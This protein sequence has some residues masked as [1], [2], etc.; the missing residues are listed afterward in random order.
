MREMTAG[1]RA[2]LAVTDV[3]GSPVFLPV[4]TGTFDATGTWQVS[5][6]VPPGFSGLTVLLRA[7]AMDA[8]G[9]LRDSLDEIV[10]VQ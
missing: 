4:A 9:K 2:L 3:D 7:Y 8:A 6:V 5:A 1:D 10:R